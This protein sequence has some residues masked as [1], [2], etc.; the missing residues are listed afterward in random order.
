MKVDGEIEEKSNVRKEGDIKN[1]NK[2][3]WVRSVG[4]GGEI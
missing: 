1:I 4:E 3:E 2:A